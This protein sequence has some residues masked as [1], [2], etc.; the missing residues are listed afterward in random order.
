MVSWPDLGTRVTVRYRRPAGSV[1]PLTDAVGQLLALDPMVRVRTKTGTVVQFAAADVVAVR[2]LTDAP[3][4]TSQIRALERAAAAG[5]PGIEQAWLDGWL[6]RAGHG[7]T[8]A[9]NSAVPL[10][11]SAHA[12]AIP[13][14]VAWYAHRDLTPRLAIPD[15]LLPLPAGLTSEHTERVLVRDVRD[16][17]AHEP[18]PS[19]TLSARPDDTWLQL[20]QREIPVDVLTAVLDG[21]LA[22][23]AYP[24]V[25]A[26]RAAVTG[27]PDGTRWVGLSEIRGADADH[28]R[29]YEALLAWGASRGATRGY[30]RVSDT[31][32]NTAAES[33]GFRL[34]H[35]SR[36]VRPPDNWR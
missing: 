22:F 32:A 4:R 3:V 11:I 10:D 35:R 36:Y 25:A 7:A 26:A 28:G 16:L 18:D 2:A 30:L 5:W 13:A 21:E 6:L 17:S 34:H 14:I 15:R 1:P 19:I 12:G 9:A 23:G 20:Y 33:L 27:A 24:G 31:E 8:F 29:L